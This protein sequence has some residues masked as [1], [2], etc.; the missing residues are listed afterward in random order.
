MKCAP[1]DVTQETRGRQTSVTTGRERESESRELEKK[2]QIEVHRKCNVTINRVCKG[3]GK[4]IVDQDEKERT[5]ILE[6][7][8][9]SNHKNRPTC[10]ERY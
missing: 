6:R 1:G 8:K 9:K 10:T 4:D 3:I 7:F 2:K 5:D